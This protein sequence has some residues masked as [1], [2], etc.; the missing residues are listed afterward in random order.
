[1]RSARWKDQLPAKSIVAQVPTFAS[2]AILAENTN[3]V[4]PGPVA[5]VLARVSFVQR[6]HHSAMLAS[7]AAP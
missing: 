3:A 2:A 1:L 4:L 5:A 7:A 6:R